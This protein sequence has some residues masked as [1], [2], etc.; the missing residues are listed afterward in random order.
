MFQFFR[1]S[2][3]RWL[4]AFFLMG[5][6]LSIIMVASLAFYYSRTSLEAAVLNQLSVVNEIRKGQILS[7]LKERIGDVSVLSVSGDVVYALKLMQAYYDIDDGGTDGFF[8]MTAKEYKDIYEGIDPFFRRY[9][10]VFGYQDIYLISGSQGHVMYTAEHDRDLRTNLKTGPYKDSGLARL[11]AKV[12]KERKAAIE[13]FTEYAA[14]GKV[15]AFIGAPVFDEK[16]EIVTAVIAVQVSAE[17]IRG[18]MKEKENMRKTGETYIV[19]EDFLIRAHWG[20]DKTPADLKKKIDTITVR[21]GLKGQTGIE[22]T[23]N[24]QGVNVLSSYSLIGIKELGADFKWVIIS[25]IEESEAYTP[26]RHLG[27]Q[28][29]WVGII[30]MVFECTV[31]YFTVRSIAM[32]LRHLCDKVTL[33]A[34]G[35]LTIT[36]QPGTRLDEIGTLIDAFYYMLGTLRSQTQQIMEGTHTIASSIT[37]ISSTATQLAASSA[38]TSSSVSEITTTVEEVRQTAYIANEKADEVAKGADQASHTYDAG[39][40]ATEDAISG[41]NRIKEEME[42]VAESIVKLSEQ[43]QSIGEIISAVNDLA[44]QSNLLSVNA[45]IE[46][47]KAGEHGR[48]FAVVAQEVKSLADQSKAATNQIKTILNDIQKATSTAVMATERGSKAVEAGVQLSIQSGDSIDRLSQSVMES[49]YATVQIAASNQEQLTGMDQLLQ[50]ME[51]IKDASMQNVDGARQ[52]ETATKNLD[53]LGQ[54]L[55]QLGLMFKF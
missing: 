17:Q 15:G 38:E 50:A 36:I 39:K 40:K 24:Y 3:M 41:M 9:L 31:G 10:E 18:I 52:L 20:H 49:T 44:D 11:W 26:V 1:K 42:Y 30:L 16:K 13:D 23:K 2:V 8:D 45:S 5:A 53:E 28:I 29:F 32:P 4:V 54:N 25:E 6:L 33:M 22:I 37:Q 7:Y 19:G 51:S 21:K 27:L 47:A 43:T 12:V 35:D 48:G 14:T 46:A 34:D 55:K